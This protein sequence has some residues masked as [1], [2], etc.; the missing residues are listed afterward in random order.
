[1]S[2]IALI[3]SKPGHYHFGAVKQYRCFHRHWNVTLYRQSLYN[4]SSQNL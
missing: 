4:N 3:D 2:E 1:M